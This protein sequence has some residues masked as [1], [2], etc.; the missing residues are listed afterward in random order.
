VINALSLG[1]VKVLAVV[2]LVA[3]VVL[4]AVVGFLIQRAILKMGLLSVIVVLF[5]LVWWQR[6][7]VVGCAKTGNCTF[8]G[9]D[10]KAVAD[11]VP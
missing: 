5:A 3:L 7:A 8:F 2:V 6:S 4:G 9:V 10:V 11:R 1:Q